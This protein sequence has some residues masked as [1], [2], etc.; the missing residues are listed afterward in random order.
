M[1]NML[2]ENLTENGS[3][4][5]NARALSFLFFGLLNLI[6]N[7]EEFRFLP[8]YYTTFSNTIGHFDQAL[9]LL[10]ETAS[11][12]RQLLPT[13]EFVTDILTLDVKYS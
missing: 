9:L 7:K 10:L 1:Q 4:L 2:D 11:H 5:A 8:H 3:K 13:L 12:C 6:D